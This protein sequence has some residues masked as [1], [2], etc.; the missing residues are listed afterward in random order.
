M[1]SAALLLADLQGRVSLSRDELKAF[2]VQK[3]DVFFTR[4]SETAVEVGMTSVMLDE[5]QENSFQRF[6]FACPA[7]GQQL[8]FTS[9]RN[10]VFS[11]AGCPESR[12][13]RKAQKPR[14]AADKWQIPGCR[15]DSPPSET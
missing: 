1:G 15:F 8:G 11:T 3:G 12:S 10:T 5:T 4:T 14:R 6:R 7:K 2:E 13:P 9:S